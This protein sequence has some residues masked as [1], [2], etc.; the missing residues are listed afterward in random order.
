MLPTQVIKY[1]CNACNKDIDDVTV[2]AEQVEF[3]VRKGLEHSVSMNHSLKSLIYG[4]SQCPHCESNNIEITLGEFQAREHSMPSISY[5]GAKTFRQKVPDG[6][7][8]VLGRIKSGVA[9]GENMKS[10]VL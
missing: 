1:K 7:K 2:F 4:H 6:F 8:D 3:V 5:A 9:G 10:S